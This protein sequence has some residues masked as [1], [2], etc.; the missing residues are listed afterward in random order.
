MKLD[1]KTAVI[2]AF[3]IL[4]LMIPI[5]YA[6]KKGISDPD[7][8]AEGFFHFSFKLRNLLLILYSAILL[9]VLILYV[10]YKISGGQ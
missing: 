9:V 8:Y 5:V 6:Q 10:W 1:F 4:I 7:E 3:I 2:A